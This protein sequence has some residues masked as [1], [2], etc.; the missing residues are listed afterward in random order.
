MVL[1]EMISCI[2]LSRKISLNSVFFFNLLSNLLFVLTGHF[3]EQRK[4]KKVKNSKYEQP[5]S[6]F[7]AL[8]D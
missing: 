4:V 1:S 7:G 5:P 6:D 3:Y 8:E 2:F